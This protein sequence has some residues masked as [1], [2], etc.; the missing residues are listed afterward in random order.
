MRILVLFIQLPVSKQ[1]EATVQATVQVTVQ[2]TV[3]AT[4]QVTVQATVQVI[5]IARMHT[6][7]CNM[8]RTATVN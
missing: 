5:L 8:R 6:C 7:P 1:K 2:A 4:V 3:Q